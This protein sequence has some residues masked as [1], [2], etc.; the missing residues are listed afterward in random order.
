MNNEE[1]GKGR[2]YPLL[3]GKISVHRQR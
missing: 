1:Q 2:A 3:S